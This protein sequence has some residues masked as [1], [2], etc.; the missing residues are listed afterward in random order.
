MRPRI[1]S[2]L[3]FAALLSACTDNPQGQ[4]PDR[5]PSPGTVPEEVVTCFGWPSLRMYYGAEST[6]KAA[7]ER[8]R[9][10]GV[11]GRSGQSRVTRIARSQRGPPWWLSQL[12]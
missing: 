10:L 5:P 1:F 8:L 12:G 7:R 2:T 3:A 6:S 4:G 11:K 9:D